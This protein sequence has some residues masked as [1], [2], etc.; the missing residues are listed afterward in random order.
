M[1]NSAIDSNPWLAGFTDADGHF[2]INIHKRTNRNSIRVQLFYRLEI[3]H[4][5]NI[6]D[7][8]GEQV[9]FFAIISKL[10]NYFSTNVLSRK[11][12]VENKD[13][14]SFIVM[15]ASKSSLIKTSDY[16]NKY[17]L[18][19]SK[20]LDYKSWLYILELQKNCRQ[21]RLFLI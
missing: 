15:S 12:I 16:F 14:F 21:K 10:A 19:S 6:L 20:F 4:T 2:S 17:P 5:Y 1:F 18:L 7:N 9:S 8:N 3:R 13:F 11:R